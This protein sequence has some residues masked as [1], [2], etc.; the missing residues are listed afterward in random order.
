MRLK[1]YI[2]IDHFT[3]KKKVAKFSEEHIFI[4]NKGKNTKENMIIDDII[5]FDHSFIFF[6]ILDPNKKYRYS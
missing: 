4:K 5:L 2:S 1:K 3:K 6:L